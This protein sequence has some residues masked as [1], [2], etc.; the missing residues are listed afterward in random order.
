MKKKKNSLDKCLKSRLSLGEISDI[1]Q[2]K[3]SPALI[4]LQIEITNSSLV[5]TGGISVVYHNDLQSGLGPQV[6]N[7]SCNVP[8][9]VVL[10]ALSKQRGLQ[11][12]CAILESFLQS[13]STIRNS[14][15]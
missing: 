13:V 15:K 6:G 12:G 9:Y 10:T 5:V 2:N 1:L 4:V 11:A 8:V 7:T 3:R 14:K